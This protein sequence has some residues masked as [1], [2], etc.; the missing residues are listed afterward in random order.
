M[1]DLLKN[2]PF[3]G[4]VDLQ[5][6]RTI[7]DDYDKAPRP[8]FVYYIRCCVEMSVMSSSWFDDFDEATLAIEDDAD[9]LAKKTLV[10]RWN[11]RFP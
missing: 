6:K 11:N 5:I 1:D 3:C 10:E 2:C 8:H 9:Q 4:K 7:V